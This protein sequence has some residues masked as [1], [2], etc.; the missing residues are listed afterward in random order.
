MTGGRI[1]EDD[2]SVDI[3]IVC[4]SFLLLTSMPQCK[5]SVGLPSRCFLASRGEERAP[6][7][8]LD[9]VHR[10]RHLPT[11]SQHGERGVYRA[12]CGL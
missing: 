7:L 2:M 3:M 5:C 1:F 4:S 10:A 9:F 8:G 11:S 6:W 12:L